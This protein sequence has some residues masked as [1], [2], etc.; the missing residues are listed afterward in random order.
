M[1][2]GKEVA[3][4][5]QRG[6]EGGRRLLAPGSQDVRSHRGVS[7]AAQ[8]SEGTIQGRFRLVGIGF[9]NR[10]IGPQHRREGFHQFGVVQDG[11]RRPLAAAQLGSK[12]GLGQGVH[13]GLGG[14]QPWCPVAGHEQARRQRAVEPAQLAD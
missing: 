7:L 13:F 8:G 5:Q 6:F 2:E 9:A 1:G 14:G 3:A 4:G 12:L 10:E 11:V